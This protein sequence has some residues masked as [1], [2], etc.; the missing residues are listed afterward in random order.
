MNFQISHQ[1]RAILS[2]ILASN[3]LDQLNKIPEGFRNNL[4]WNIAHIVATQQILVYRLSGLDA[5]VDHEF[6]DTF[7]K[8]TS[9]LR[10]YTD[11]D[12]KYLA[13]VLKS[14]IQMTQ[15]DYHSGKFQ[16]FSPYETSQGYILNSV[17]DSLFFNEFHE[18]L[19]L[20]I[21]LQILKFL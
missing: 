9:P 3:S 14:T 13:K 1:T 4:F 11:E 5:L 2:K 7:K 18:G 19:H 15:E 21:M 10:T 6:I 8:G 16:T 12:R 17:E 20:G